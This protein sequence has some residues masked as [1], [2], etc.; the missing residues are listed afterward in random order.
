MVFDAFYLN[1]P[2][3]SYIDSF[4]A[5]DRDRND[6]YINSDL[7]EIFSSGIPIVHGSINQL[8]NL[9]KINLDNPALSSPIK[10][11]LLYSWDY[12]NDFYVS[13]FLSLM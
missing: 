5:F 7:N 8:I 10:K 6:L 11:R 12:K 13:D 1:K 2:V 3:I 9:I 4:S